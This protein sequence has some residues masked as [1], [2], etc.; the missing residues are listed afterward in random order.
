MTTERFLKLLIAVAGVAVLIALLAPSHRQP[1][2]LPSRPAPDFQ[3]LVKGQPHSLRELQ[4]KVVLL[5]FW[6]SWCEP[7]VAE[8]PSLEQLHRAFEPRGLFVLA[9]SVDENERAYEE[10]IH[11]KKLTLATYRDP[12][13]KIAARYGTFQYPETYIIDRNGLLQKKVVGPIDWTDPQVVAYLNQLLEPA[14]NLS[15]GSGTGSTPGSSR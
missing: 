3:Y 9:I 14:S 6:A 5:N 8:M 13:K 1:S 15:T 4:G 12:Q 2:P 10:F 7:C 11:E